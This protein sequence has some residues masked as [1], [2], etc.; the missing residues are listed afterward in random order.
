MDR[1]IKRRLTLPTI[2]ER[3]DHIEDE[4]PDHHRVGVFDR[5][6]SFGGV[7]HRPPVLLPS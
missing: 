6:E 3:A 1:K 2:L 4:G 5:T 7:H